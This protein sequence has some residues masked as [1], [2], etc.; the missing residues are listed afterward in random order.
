[1]ERDEALRLLGVATDHPSGS[2]LTRA[3][4]AAARRAHPD[5]HASEGEGARAAAEREMAR[6]NEAYDLLRG[7]AQSGR[8][9]GARPAGPVTSDPAAPPTCPTA[10]RARSAT[11]QP[12]PAPRSA[13]RMRTSS[14]RRG[15]RR[16]SSLAACLAGSI[17][18][19]ITLG[20]VSSWRGG[21]L[22][23]YPPAEY[24]IAYGALFSWLLLCSYA[25]LL[26]LRD[27]I[28]SRRPVAKVIVA[29]ACAALALWGFYALVQLLA[30]LAGGLARDAA[31]CVAGLAAL[32]ASVAWLIRARPER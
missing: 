10:A 12:G 24:P 28:R 26:V 3:Y 25:P 29:E 27:G 31:F 9:Q 1:M 19:A 7:K 15:R 23:E 21:G 4:R 2:E 13:P 14:L 17:V 18:L 6:V 5:A 8:P 32:V 20:T 22:V 16:R 11:S 30:P